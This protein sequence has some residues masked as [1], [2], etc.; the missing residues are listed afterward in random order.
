MEPTSADLAERFTEA[1]TAAIATGFCTVRASETRAC[2]SAPGVAQIGAKRAAYPVTWLPVCSFA[3][4]PPLSSRGAPEPRHTAPPSSPYSDARFRC[5]ASRRA[6]PPG[7]RFPSASPSPRARPAARPSAPARGPSSIIRFVAFPPALPPPRRVRGAT[8]CS[9]R[10]ADAPGAK[11]VIPEDI[12]PTSRSSSWSRCRAASASPRWSPP[13]PPCR[14]RG[15]HRRARDQ[16]RPRRRQALA[17]RRRHRRHHRRGVQG[18]AH[19]QRRRRR[20]RRGPRAEARH[21]SPDPCRSNDWPSA[22]AEFKGKPY[23]HGDVTGVVRFV[24][25][26]EDTCVVEGALEGWFRVRRTR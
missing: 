5:L 16:H 12:P 18:E 23:G 1:A 26:N 25:V 24:A 11:K 10:R 17:R 7:A 9:S 21:R 14:G 4:L 13:S 2:G 6:S 8:R 19:R 15:R 20:V 22:V 3:R